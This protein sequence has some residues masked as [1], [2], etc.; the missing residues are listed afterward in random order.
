V[1]V[2]AVGALLLEAAKQFP[3][4]RAPKPKLQVGGDGLSN[5]FVAKAKVAGRQPL[6]VAFA[7]RRA[8]SSKWKR[9]DVD[10]SP[11]YRAFLDPARFKKHARLQ[12]VAIARSLD[13]STATSKVVGFRLL[14]R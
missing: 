8:G 3:V 14:G 2:P 6:T 4:A 1:T 11:P 9:L 10:D 5:L 7:Y 13:G 12:L